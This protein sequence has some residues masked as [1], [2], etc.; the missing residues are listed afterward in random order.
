MVLKNLEWILKRIMD[1]GL[2]SR[3]LEKP[4]MDSDFGFGFGFWI[5]S[6]GLKK[7]IMDSDFGFI[8]LNGF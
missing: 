2:S 4:I 6:P 1:F 7:P 8:V 5:N 3:G